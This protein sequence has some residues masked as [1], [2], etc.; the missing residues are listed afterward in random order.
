MSNCRAKNGME[1]H[2]YKSVMYSHSLAS[3]STLLYEYYAP[4]VCTPEKHFSTNAC[5]KKKHTH[6][7]LNTFQH[8]VNN[9]MCCS[10][11]VMKNMFCQELDSQMC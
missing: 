10:D 4:V 7:P 6:T 8:S 9:L 5:V 2:R 11:V 3:G 1:A